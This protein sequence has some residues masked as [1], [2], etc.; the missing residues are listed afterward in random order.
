MGNISFR[1]RNKQTVIARRTFVFSVLMGVLMISP[2]VEGSPVYDVFGLAFIGLVA[3]ITGFVMVVFYLRR[4]KK[5]NK[6]VNG[7]NLMAHWVMEPSVI[8]TYVEKMFSEQRKKN[9]MLLIIITVLFVVISIPFGIAA[10]DDWLTFVGIIFSVYS[11]ILLAGLLAPVYFKYRNMKGNGMVLIGAKYIYI[12]G[13]FHNWD[14]PQSGLQSLELVNTPFRGMRVVY[15]YKER[16]M[17]ND[18]EL[19]IPVPETINVEEL[20]T[21]MDKGN[22]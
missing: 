14:F 19:I 4:A 13:D 21:K 1:I 16:N 11:V 10:E 6:L 7:E 18:F 12:N 3:M 20:L 8:K 22:Q 17:T 5:Q 15:F 9:K 2:F